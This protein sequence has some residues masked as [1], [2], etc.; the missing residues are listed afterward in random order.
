MKGMNKSKVFSILGIVASA[1]ISTLLSTAMQDRE[2]D[3]CVQ[4]HLD[5]SKD[6]EG[7]A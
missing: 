6:E 5:A 1:V 3:K 4:E 7:E 2:I